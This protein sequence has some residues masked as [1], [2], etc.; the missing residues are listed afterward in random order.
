MSSYLCY[1]N[2]KTNLK[3]AFRDT[4]NKEYKDLFLFF[5]K[6]QKNQLKQKIIK[7]SDI[8]LIFSYIKLKKPLLLIILLKLMFS[9]FQGYI[10]I[11]CFINFNIY[12]FCL[13]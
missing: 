2:L 6:C 13:K 9:T 12:L 10:S 1:L 11:F 4:V 3:L 7:H 5:F 8:C